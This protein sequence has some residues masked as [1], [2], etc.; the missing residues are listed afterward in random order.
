[1]NTYTIQ[2]YPEGW[3]P[4]APISVFT[5]QA[6]QLTTTEDYIVFLDASNPPQ[7]VF[8]V[9]FSVNPV[10]TRTVAAA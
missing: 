8:L 9:P 5:V 3:S 6:T 4:T 10:V 1:M 2:I 7:A